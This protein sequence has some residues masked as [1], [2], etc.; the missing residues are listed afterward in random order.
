M[1]RLGKK[2]LKIDYD[3]RRFCDLTQYIVFERQM[4]TNYWVKRVFSYFMRL[5][6]K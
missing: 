5:I 4:N 1:F 3:Y 2:P 6:A